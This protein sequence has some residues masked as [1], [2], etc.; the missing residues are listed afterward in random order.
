MTT[1]VIFFNI[2]IISGSFHPV[3]FT[4]RLHKFPAFCTFSNG[5]LRWGKKNTKKRKFF[6]FFEQT[7]KIFDIEIVTPTTTTT[8][9]LILQPFN[10]SSTFNFYPLSQG[11]LKPL[12]CKII[13]SNIYKMRVF[14]YVRISCFLLRTPSLSLSLFQIKIL[15]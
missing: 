10:P 3:T 9:F 1:N 5:K 15:L 13:N 4:T 12:L 7:N 8:I 11:W 2:F 6:S 14:A